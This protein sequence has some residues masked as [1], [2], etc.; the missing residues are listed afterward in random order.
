MVMTEYNNNFNQ[1]ALKMQIIKRKV[2]PECLTG[3]YYS[4]VKHDIKR[5]IKDDTE[6]LLIRIIPKNPISEKWILESLMYLQ[7]EFTSIIT[8]PKNNVNMKKEEFEEFEMMFNCNI[9]L[10]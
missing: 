2:D 7:R 1:F 10:D 8:V 4:Q 5:K 3:L 6:L 9:L